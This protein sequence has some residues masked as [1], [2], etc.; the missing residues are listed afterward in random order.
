MGVY[1]RERGRIPDLVLCSSAKRACQTL[2]LLRKIEAGRFRSEL[3]T[4][5]ASDSFPRILRC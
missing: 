5:A 3:R 4:L 1:I 2:D